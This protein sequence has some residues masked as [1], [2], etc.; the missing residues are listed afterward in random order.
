MENVD[1]QIRAGSDARRV[2]GRDCDPHHAAARVR[3]RAGRDASVLLQETRGAELGG[4][5]EA[6]RE[7]PV[8][9]PPHRHESRRSSE[10]GEVG[11]PDGV[12]AEL[13]GLAAAAEIPVRDQPAPF[14]ELAVEELIAPFD[15]VGEEGLRVVGGPPRVTVSE[16]N[17]NPPPPPPPV[18]LAVAVESPAQSTEPTSPFDMKCDWFPGPPPPPVSLA[19]AKLG[20]RARGP[21]MTPVDESRHAPNVS[22]SASAPHRPA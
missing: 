1:A 3:R 22:A 15:E 20:E 5:A 18:S 11:I 12:R 2:V 7:E 6:L 4:P 14:E 10:R 9:I 13:E 8:G 21:P 17:V 16:P 19:V